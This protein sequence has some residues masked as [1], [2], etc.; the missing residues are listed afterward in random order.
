M[1][2]RKR[3]PLL[4][5][6]YSIIMLVGGDT[7]PGRTTQPLLQHVHS[8]SAG[9]INDLQYWHV[10]LQKYQYSAWNVHVLGRII[11]HIAWQH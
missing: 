6:S 10:L 3:W 5:V 4:V 1:F 9:H 8:D 7:T 11:H 2:F